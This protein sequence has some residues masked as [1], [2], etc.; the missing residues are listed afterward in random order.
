MKDAEGG[1]A[2]KYCSDGYVHISF[3]GYRGWTASFVSYVVPLTFLYLHSTLM[4]VAYYISLL[5]FLYLFAH[6]PYFSHLQY[7]LC[8][9][10]ETIYMLTPSL[11]ILSYTSSLIWVSP[12]S[13]IPFDYLEL[14]TSLYNHY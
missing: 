12:T 14:P 11:H 6:F 5:V 7:V 1:F 10:K 2:A 4:F 9:T 13:H 8:F 3:V